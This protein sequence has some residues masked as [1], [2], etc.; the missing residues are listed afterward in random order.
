MLIRYKKDSKGNS[1]PFAKI[2]TKDEHKIDISLIDRDAYRAVKKLQSTGAEA[3]IVGGAVRDLMLNK[4]PKDF[5]ITTSASPRQIHKLFWNSRIIGK[6]FK[7]VHLEYGNKI[8]EVSTFRSD[9]ENFGINN[10]VFGTVDQDAKRRD[11]TINALYYDPINEQVFDFNDAMEDFKK[12]RISSIIDLKTSFTEDPVRMLRAI[13]YSITTGYRLRFNIKRAIKNNH[14]ELSKVSTSRLTE[15]VNKILASGYSRDIFIKLQKYKLLV[16]L[17]P[18]FNIYASLD[19]VQNSLLELDY[20]VRQYKN[21]EID[22]V[23]R[24]IMLLHLVKELIIFSDEGLTQ[25]ERFKETFRQIKV[26]ISPMTPSNYEVELCCA[27]LLKMKGYKVPKGCVRHP[28]SNKNN[29]NFERR[30]K[31]SS[32]KKRNVKKYETAKRK[33]KPITQ[34]T[35]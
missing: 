32:N 34:T 10:N 26:L 27:Q 23:A 9:E 1:I 18:C 29:V 33:K 30:R 2:Y 13:K 24:H 15:E 17:L 25:R 14:S 28:K 11:F 20:K 4:N 19:S 5:D 8:L 12:K 35:N 6:R 16:Y 22:E 21:G 3:Y 7:L 31:Y